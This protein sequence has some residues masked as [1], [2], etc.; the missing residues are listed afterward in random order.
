MH[1]HYRYIVINHPCVTYVLACIGACTCTWVYMY[2]SKFVCSRHAWMY[3]CDGCWGHWM[4]WWAN[5]SS[6]LS[7]MHQFTA[8]G[9]SPC[10]SDIG[11]EGYKVANYPV[12]LQTT[13]SNQLRV[14]K[15]TLGMCSW[16]NEHFPVRLYSHFS[17]G[18]KVATTEGQWLLKR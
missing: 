3:M 5:Q 12:N 8:K 6:D 9:C 2:I 17:R 16:T 1:E 4:D 18:T 14:P 13:K 7:H 15:I 11:S 10:C